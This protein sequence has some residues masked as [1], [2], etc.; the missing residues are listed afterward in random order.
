MVQAKI[1]WAEVGLHSGGKG[2]YTAIDAV[3]GE[4]TKQ[5]GFA[6]RDGGTVLVYGA[7]SNDPIQVDTLDT[8][9]KYKKVE[10]HHSS[11]PWRKENTRLHLSAFM[12]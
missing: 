5:L 4:M 3:S 8:L 1:C 11:F 7:L 10:V 6:L 2:A 12:Q 9:Y